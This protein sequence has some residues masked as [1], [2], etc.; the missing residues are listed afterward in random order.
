MRMPRCRVVGLMA[1]AAICRGAE[2]VR[3]TAQPQKFRTFYSLDDPRVPAALKP[4]GATARAVA[5]DGAV[6][7]G[8]QH[9]ATRIDPKA[10]PRDRS[11]YF[12]GKRYLPDDEVQQL[13]ADQAAGMWVRTK[14]GVSHIELRTMTLAAKAALFEERVHARHDRHGLVSPSNLGVPGDVSTNQMRD[15]DNDGLWTSMYAAAE[16]FRYA[17]THS[18]AALA[19]GAKST[20]AVLFLEGDLH[21]SVGSGIL[22]TDGN[23]FLHVTGD[24]TSG[25]G[26]G[27]GG[28]MLTNWANL[29]VGGSYTQSASVLNLDG[30]GTSFQS[31]SFTEDATS[32]VHMTNTATAIVN[33]SFTNNGGGIN[34]QSGSTLTINGDLHESVGSGILLTDGNTFLH[35]TGDLT[36]GPG[37]GSG[38]VGLTNWANRTVGGSYTQSASILNLD[39]IGTTFQSGSFTEDATSGV[40]MTNTATAIVDR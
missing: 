3:L 5:S 25:S 19:N 2:P 21:E 31:G 30:I 32:G 7:Y 12:A 22:L 6:W 35:V 34:L 14:T 23:T 4:P 20:E 15:D 9:G 16:C 1:I 39:G 33:G 40:H 36:S 10:P 11:Q 28:V 13:A 24:L 8:T 18:P 38:G 29:T 37:T 26:T 27:S 17:V